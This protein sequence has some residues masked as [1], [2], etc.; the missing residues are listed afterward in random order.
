MQNHQVINYIFESKAM[1]GVIDLHTEQLRGALYLS[2]QNG[3]ACVCCIFKIFHTGANIS[4]V[5]V[6]WGYKLYSGVDFILIYLL[7]AHT[8]D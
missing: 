7:L 4:T 3:H 6:E 5:G 2:K 8:A 1:D